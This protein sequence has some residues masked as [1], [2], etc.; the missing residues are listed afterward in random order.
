MDNQLITLSETQL[1]HLIKKSI[2]TYH[3]AHYDYSIK[4]ISSRNNNPTEKKLTFKVE[5]RSKDL[6]VH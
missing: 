6:A 1:K 3:D 4:D 2:D 5:I